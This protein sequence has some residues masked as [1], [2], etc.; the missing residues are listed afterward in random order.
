MEYFSFIKNK[1][2]ISIRLSESRSSLQNYRPISIKDI[3]NATLLKAFLHGQNQINNFIVSSSK[4]EFD[5]TLKSKA[6]RFLFL[7]LD[8]DFWKLN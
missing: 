1:K 4:K 5:D 3:Y 8:L 7:K 6:F 2:L